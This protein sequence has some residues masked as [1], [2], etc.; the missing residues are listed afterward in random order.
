MDIKYKEKKMIRDKVDIKYKEKKK[1][2]DKVGRE[3][4]VK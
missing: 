1:E 3:S 2:K 4:R